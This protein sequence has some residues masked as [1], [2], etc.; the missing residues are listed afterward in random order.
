MIFN[1]ASANAESPCIPSVL[2]R[3]YLY[4][5]IQRFGAVC[6]LLSFSAAHALPPTV[7]SPT[8]D[9]IFTQGD[10]VSLDA[11]AAFDDPEGDA[12]SFIAS[13][14][15]GSLSIN[16]NTGVI[17]GTITNADWLN[18]PLLGY[19][20]T[21]TAS[22]GNSGSADDTFLITINNLNDAPFVD[23]PT[24]NQTYVQ[25]DNVN[26]DAGAAFDDPDGDDL[27]FGA[28]GLPASLSINTGTGVITGTITNADW[29][30][31]PPPGYS[32]TVT[33][34]DGNGESVNDV[35]T[36][37]INNLN[38]QPVVVSPTP[39]QT[40]A[41][42]DNVN[43]GAGAAFDDPDGDDLSFGASGLPASLSINTGTGVI[44]GTITNADWLN[45]PPSGYSVTVT[46]DDGNGESVNDAFIIRINNLNDQP[47]V[48]SPMP[49]QTYAQ[50]DNVNLNAGA[51]FDDPDG[52]ALSFVASGL[53]AS[54]SINS[55]TGVITGVITNADVLNG[56]VYSVTVTA[57]D[58]SGGVSD[59]FTITV[60][61]T[62]DQPVVVSPTPDQTYTQ[63][64]NVNLNAGA[65][66][67]DPDGDDL[68]FVASG[69][70][71]S[72]SINTGTGV[73]TGTV[74]NDDWLNGPGYSVTVTAND[75][76]GGSASDA[77]AITINN[78][79]DA[80]LA[81]NDS[82]P[83]I[84]EGGAITN[85][86][87]VLDNDSDP[88]NDPLSAVL[89]DGPA[90]AANFSLNSNG[91][92]LYRHDGSD[93][94]SDSFTYRASDGQDQSG[95][96]TV[97]ISIN[98]VNDEPVAV[99]DGPFNVDEGGSFSSSPASVLDN[100]TDS[101]GDALTAVLVTG[102]ANAAAFTLNPNGTFTYTHNGSETTSDSFT[103]VADDGSESN[104]ATVTFTINPVNDAP[105][106]IDDAPPGIDEG[107]S[108]VGTF[109]VLANDTDAESD[110]LVAVIVTGPANAASFVLNPDG[111]FN[112]EHDGS[113]TTSDS[114]TYQASD[115]NVV[116]GTSNVATVS[117]AI[118]G[119]NDDPEVVNPMTER[120]E[121][122]ERTAV[123]GRPFEISAAES[124]ADDDGD[125]L[126]YSAIGLPASL[127]I[128]P[129][130]GLISGTPTF[131]D[132]RD[133]EPYVV[134]V[135]A[136]DGM[137]GSLVAV[138]TFDLTVSALDRAN[139]A[140]LID[141]NSNSA[142]LAE[143]LRWTFS[144]INPVGPQPGQDVELVGSFVGAGLTVT[145]EA[146]AN[147]TIA[148]AVDMVTD[149][150]CVF[151]A[152]PVGATVS[153]V[154]TTS[155]SQA[156]EV[157][158]FATA[159][160][161]NNL[162][163]DPNNE[164]NSAIESAG[165]AEA[166]SNGWVQLLGSASA[167]S[168]TAGDV[169]ADGR[170]DIIVGTQ[171]GDQVQIYFG[172]VP[173][174]SCNCPRDFLTSPLSIP[175]SA[176]NEGV[177]LADFDSNGSLDL[178]VAVGGGLVDV[179]Y[180]NDGTG[181]FGT[182]PALNLDPSFA[183]GAA[184][185]DFNGDGNRDIVIAS[186]GGNAV[187]LGDGLGGF[188]RETS[189][190][191][192][193]SVDVAVADFDGDGLDDLVF[194]NVD[195]PSQVWLRDPA[196]GF[197]AGSVLDIG[198][199]S[200]VASADLNAAGGPDLV[201]GRVPADVGDIPANPVLLNNGN[202]GFDTPSELLGLSPTN[203]VQIGEINGDGLPDLVFLNASGVH[204]I[205]TAGAGGYVL[206][207]EQIIDA[208]VRAGVVTDLGFTDN[209]NPG[210]NDLAM[211]GANLAGIGVYLNDGAGNLGR[212]D[213]VPPVIEL[214][215]QAAV[216][217]PSGSSYSDAGATAADNIDGDITAEIVVT[218]SVNTAVVG[219]YTLTYNVADFAGNQ[220]TQV[221]RTVSVTPAIGTGGGGGG[222]LSL[223][224]LVA[225][226]GV[227]VYC[228]LL[229]R[230]HDRSARLTI[231]IRK[232]GRHD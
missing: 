181:N 190:G 14:L 60:N 172:D 53:P 218:G 57:N 69:L 182:V 85:S 93:T 135:E 209:A 163:I 49:N 122:A 109:N 202:G 29:L 187:Y 62:N 68:S 155:A 123:E 151:G 108:I 80:P 2:L 157:V 139:L 25:G 66:F 210:G 19:S 76:N 9:Q 105:V 6:L 148:A 33:A 61:N 75:G 64:D 228:E 208:G 98:S 205:W 111:T 7:P 35:F 70:P 132:A 41:Q 120:T 224:L 167:R 20:V 90:N 3:G 40:Y 54:L 230:H 56:P 227:L 222:S 124:F 119:V 51:A 63:G 152:L 201:F 160:G 5:R 110:P 99:D 161:A 22:D 173:R 83:A 206:H 185:G 100:D 140:L 129:A 10:S 52:D 142:S 177:A 199:A 207:R 88:D 107:G 138:D 102:P 232:D 213:A 92:F 176:A 127:S 81:S 147:C 112:Y 46:A 97:T 195:G 72:L 164:D 59:G 95:I 121:S 145:A 229:R 27:S 117:I 175:N 104:T 65:A 197:V 189:L 137:P 8:P 168:I 86:F 103:Y 193:N 170:V 200:S 28:S 171:A 231:R 183:H 45:E 166:F 212:G 74:T 131:E 191:T 48:V 198:D 58:G 12:L 225:L 15:P 204:Q 178:V 219:S 18:E 13:G 16:A 37:R 130:T 55:G 115:G 26:L 165:V 89:A 144:A 128:D 31:E 47:I 4:R 96:A 36:I 84:D 203:D 216:E 73:I 194:A 21:V 179:V 114:F 125:V 156:S 91:D 17:T 226:L 77:F 217:V 174:E 149:F 188:A 214:L 159:A 150:V 192:A 153:T 32:V 1:S 71:A 134:S 215:G 118:A 34:D 87:N 162:P 136:S 78:V 24:V 30:N 113:E 186:V 141:V 44:T 158:A 169:N 223:A 116:N 101:E 196:G 126:T 211:G 23:A 43:L 133:D 154:L 106:A 38:D 39:D 67:D 82:P 184:T 180:F 143:S 94:T 11:G 42:G 79:N 221:V 146:G 220:A 50:G